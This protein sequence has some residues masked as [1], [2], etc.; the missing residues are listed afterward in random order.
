MAER[1]IK[2]LA[3]VPD[4]FAALSDEEQDA[5]ALAIADALIAELGSDA[6][7]PAGGDLPSG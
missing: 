2:T 1:P 5:A 7:T 4:N 6:A 3:E